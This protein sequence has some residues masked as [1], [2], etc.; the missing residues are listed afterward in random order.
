MKRRDEPD[1]QAHIK[2]LEAV[3]AELAEQQARVEAEITKL[4]EQVSLG[5]EAA[6]DKE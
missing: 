6:L 3:K 5:G 2:N 1:V 4:P